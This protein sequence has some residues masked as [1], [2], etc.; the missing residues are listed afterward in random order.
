MTLEEENARLRS[1]NIR[2]QAEQTRL[3][4]ALAAALERVAAL[5]ARLAALQASKATPSF[6]KAATP[7]KEPKTR[8]RRAAEHNKGRRRESPTEIVQHA[9][10]HCPDC[11]YRLRGQSVARTRQVLDLPRP[12]PIVVTE[13]QILKRWCPHCMRWRTPHIDWQAAGIAM[14]QG[15]LGQRLV[16]LL[17]YLRTVAR[18][19]VRTIQE[20]LQTLHGLHLSVGAITGVLD[21]LAQAAA[22]AREELL[23]QVRAS[24][25]VHADETGWRE[26]GRNGYIWT[27]S[28]P[29]RD[30]V[31]LFHR[32]ASRAGAVLTGLLGERYPGC[33]VSDFYAAYSAHHG[34]HQRC[35][36]HLLR[37][38]H[39]LGEDHPHDATVAAWR[40]AVRALY[41]RAQAVLRHPRRVPLSSAE[42]QRLFAHYEERAR[43]LGLRYADHPAHPCHTLAHR[44]LRFHGQLFEF[45]RTP[46]VHA[47]NNLAERSLRPLVIARKISGGSR[48]P[49]GSTTRMTLA[50]L[51]A[52]W[53]ARSLNPFDQ[54]RDLLRHPHSFLPV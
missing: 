12:T 43:Q 27:L 26:A 19:P 24:P 28:T 25:A 53:Q 10:E 18:L 31:R 48:S 4:T 46:G 21:R 34:R 14:G 32:D 39:Q 38:L 33:V 6:V 51:F 54:C 23:A 40:T 2:L 9:L 22:P 47:D 1:E 16:A 37:D 15:R 13:H 36:V 20:Y 17:A 42:R 35:W 29:G 3:T 52:T 11:G 7:R 45:V 44:L 50:S 30:G 41:D 49:R 8:K 5:E